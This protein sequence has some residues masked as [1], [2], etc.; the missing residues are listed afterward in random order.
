MVV[1]NNLMSII[2]EPVAKRKQEIVLTDV[3]DNS[4]KLGHKAQVISQRECL[5]LKSLLSSAS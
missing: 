2:S 5:L 4:S 1:E 3:E